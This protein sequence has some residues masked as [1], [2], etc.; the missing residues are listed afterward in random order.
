MDVRDESGATALH[1]A[2]RLSSD[3]AAEVLLRHGWDVNA[4]DRQRRTPLHV[5][6]SREPP[7]TA[8]I[9]ALLRAGASLYAEDAEAATPLERAVALPGEAG[10]DVTTLLLDSA[11][12]GAAALMHDT[13]ALNFAAYFGNEAVVALLLERGADRRLRTTMH[14]A[15]LHMVAYKGHAHLVRMLVQAG[16]EVDA[17]DIHGVTPLHVAVSQNH[18]LTACALVAYGADMY[19]P[20]GPLRPPLWLAKA[21]NYSTF[22]NLVAV[23]ALGSDKETFKRHAEAAPALGYLEPLRL[24]EVQLLEAVGPIAGL[25]DE[26]D[27]DPPLQR[28]E[29]FVALV[30]VLLGLLV[31]QRLLRLGV[32]KLRRTRAA[33]R[34][35]V[36]QRLRVQRAARGPAVKLRDV[37]DWV[38]TLAAN[39]FARLRACTSRWSKARPKPRKVFDWVVTPCLT[40]IALLRAGVAR[41]REA[42]PEPPKTQPERAAVGIVATARDTLRRRNAGGSRGVQPPSVQ[43]LPAQPPPARP[44]EPAALLQAL[45]RVA[46]AP[47][48][49]E[50]E[51]AAAADLAPEPADVDVSPLEPPAAPEPVPPPVLSPLAILDMLPLMPKPAAVA[52]APAP[53]RIAVPL[54]VPAW[55]PPPAAEPVWPAP[56][57]PEQLEPPWLEIAAVSEAPARQ[58]AAVP[59]P[60]PVWL[61]PPA[62]EPPPPPAP[63]PRPEQLK[64]KQE[65]RPAAA[66]LLC[67]VCMDAPLEGTFLPCG[68]MAACM[69]CG[70]QVMQG[71]HK[72]CPICRVACDRFLR[73]FIHGA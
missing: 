4:R 11:G 21:V 17:T 46:A 35:T 31:L 57:P 3:E 15:P 41:W 61:P 12:S 55:H 45:N 47:E 43:P 36:P 62:A 29:M 18:T 42:R 33:P 63:P 71:S 10:V 44:A 25:A 58:H 40:Q 32:R 53:Q 9:R 49:A 67:T 69:D 50:A 70:E 60:V 7:A 51:P 48:P 39:Q 54:T 26:Y 20:R 6:I 72:L 59:L 30:V 66:A 73:I 23:V 1:L 37:R 34:R 56:P 14:R 19:A 52:D 2:A 8:V 5:A 22:R 24:L 13:R 64:E 28:H 38:V 16:A 68:H 27:D 65:P